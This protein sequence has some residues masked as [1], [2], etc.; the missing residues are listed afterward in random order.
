ME[1]RNFTRVPF[2]S[3]ATVRT[4]DKTLRGEMENLSLNGMFFKVPEAL[5]MDEAV[6]VEIL[7]SGTSSALSLRIDGN[8]SRVS[9]DGVAIQFK[10][11]GLDSFI[12]LKS[13]IAYNTGDE[14]EVMKEFYTY[15]RFHE[16]HSGVNQGEADL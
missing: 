6:E 4:K 15:L 10:G 5:P 8:V 14:E 1:K 13:I 12:H 7:L 11:M 3:E 16:S 2:Q 9:N